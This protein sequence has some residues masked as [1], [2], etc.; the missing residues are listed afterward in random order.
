M[1][2]VSVLEIYLKNQWYKAQVS[3]E[4]LCL[5]VTLLDSTLDH[6]SPVQFD[7]I[8]DHVRNVRVVKNG[9]TNFGISI[10]GGKEN[11]M[12]VFISKIFKDTPADL[13][14]QLHVGT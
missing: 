6:L 2:R 13:T 10:K 11:D 8:S 14:G 3:L 4:E 1:E 7:D 9:D 5:S 12:P